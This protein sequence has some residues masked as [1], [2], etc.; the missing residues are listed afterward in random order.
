MSGHRLHAPTV[1][2]LKLMRKMLQTEPVRVRIHVDGN[3]LDWEWAVVLLYH[4]V[5]HPL[6]FL[7]C[8]SAR[9]VCRK[10]EQ[11]PH[12]LQQGEV[13]EGMCKTLLTPQWQT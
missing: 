8:V 7:C 3:Y 6:H 4:L 1:Q 5:C 13:Y 9:E 12:I 2:G 10:H 11:A